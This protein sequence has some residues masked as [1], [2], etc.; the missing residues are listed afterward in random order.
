M[1]NIAAYMEQVA[2]HYLGEPTSVRGT[3]MRWGQHGS[4]SVDLRKGT[5]YSHEANVGGGVV[6]LVRLYEPASLN[7]SLPDIMEQQFGIPKRT[8]ETLKPSTSCFGCSST[9]SSR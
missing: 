7:G 2:R 9:C 6:D 4:M 8:Q 1:T 3:E 5:F